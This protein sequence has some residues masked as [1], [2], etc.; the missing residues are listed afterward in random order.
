MKRA[1]YESFKVNEGLKFV[2]NYEYLNFQFQFNQRNSFL[3]ISQSQ[4]RYERF[5][6]GKLLV[7]IFQFLRH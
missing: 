4:L 2:T 1:D 5:R 3:M 6:L 7:C